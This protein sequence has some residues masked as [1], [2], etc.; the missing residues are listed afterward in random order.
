MP[1]ASHPH[2]DINALYKRRR[3]AADAANESGW[4]GI[5]GWAQLENIEELLDD[6]DPDGDWRYEG[7]SYPDGWQVS[8]EREAYKASWEFDRDA[9]ERTLD[10]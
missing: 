8:A 10:A 6:I 3:K 4:K 1:A 7:Y 5:Q 9:F 2:P